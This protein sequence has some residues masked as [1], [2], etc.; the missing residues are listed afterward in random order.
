MILHVKLFMEKMRAGRYVYFF[1]TDKYKQSF[2]NEYFSRIL[3]MVHAMPALNP[4]TQFAWTSNLHHIKWQSIKIMNPNPFTSYGTLQSL[5]GTLYFMLAA[6]PHQILGYQV[7]L[8][9]T[10]LQYIDLSIKGRTDCFLGDLST[11]CVLTS[12][13]SARHLEKQVQTVP[14]Y[15]RY[16]GG[17]VSFSN[18]LDQIQMNVT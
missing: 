15:K 3:T 10:S 7:N 17:Y 1:D 11:N 9:D 18:T 12:Y 8:S 16:D 4:P 2:S 5:K 14:Y 6:N 13:F